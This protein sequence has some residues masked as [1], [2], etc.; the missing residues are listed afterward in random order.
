MKSPPARCDGADDGREPNGNFKGTGFEIRLGG[1]V[2]ARKVR[3]LW[4][5]WGVMAGHERCACACGDE[6][7]TQL[8]AWAARFGSG[9]VLAGRER[10]A[11]VDG[12]IAR[13]E[14]R[15]LRGAAQA[16]QDL[17]KGGDMEALKLAGRDLV[18]ILA[19]IVVTGEEE[20]K[21]TT[22]ETSTE[23]EQSSQQ[24]KIRTPPPAVMKRRRTCAEPVSQVNAN[25]LQLDAQRLQNSRGKT[26]RSKRKSTVFSP[27]RPLRSRMPSPRENCARSPVEQSHSSKSE[28]RNRKG[29]T[30][31]IN[32]D[33][34]LVSEL[35]RK[36]FLFESVDAEE[37]CVE[38]T[39][40][41][42]T[43]TSGMLV[44]N[45]LE[46]APV[47]QLFISV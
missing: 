18:G 4:Y 31:K 22:A 12:M 41:S 19:K 20:A 29:G 45:H 8:A 7:R 11:P 38:V 24:G 17:L 43:S 35:Q 27:V 46:A 5:R 37:L 13:G 9:D 42:S 40:K 23:N 10:D 2:G 47:N 21:T 26:Y 14:P 6:V 32:S 15:P 30:A 3:R 25:G 1:H 16:L 39:T 28:K 36:R 34:T 33:P 44:D